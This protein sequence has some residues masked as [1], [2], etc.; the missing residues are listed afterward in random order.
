LRRAGVVRPAPLA[1]TR[2]RRLAF[3]PVTGLLVDRPVGGLRPRAAVAT[4]LV[5]HIRRLAD[6]RGVEAIVLAIDS[7][8]GTTTASDQIWS[9]ARYAMARKPVVAWMR[10]YAA[11]GGY[12]VAAAAETIIASPFTITGSIGVVASKPNV[13]EAAA[14]LGVRP[15]TITRGRSA[16]I[17][18]PFHRF[19]D[20]EL[21][22]LDA[23]LD[24]S[25]ARFTSIVAEGR[26]MAV[27]EVEQVARGR[28][29]TGAQAHERGLVDRLGAFSDVVA[30]ARELAAIPSG[31]AHEV[32]W[33]G[34]REGLMQMA[35]RLVPGGAAD[36]VGPELGAL[37]EPLVLARQ[38]R[39]LYY[40]PPVWQ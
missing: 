14:R 9:A 25:Y 17:F 19:S 34:P 39:V 8:G 33:V 27:E 12:Y 20:S 38:G 24:E 18:S 28:V 40:M 29:W 21:A 37:L 10:G 31:A 7:R 36:L 35:R 3:V 1:L 26:R 2:S 23:Y 15:I 30:A 13:S 5:P 4:E 22:W 11:S 6:A 16:A 32:I